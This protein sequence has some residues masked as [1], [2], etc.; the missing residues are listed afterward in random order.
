MYVTDPHHSKQYK[1][2]SSYLA[3]LNNESI[4]DDFAYPPSWK[5]NFARLNK[6]VLIGGP[7]DGVIA[8][9][10]SAQFGCFNRKETPVPM[11]KLR[12]SFCS[13]FQMVGMWHLITWLTLDK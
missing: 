8:P 13:G 1:K 9:W 7:D 4:S 3:A 12:V 5:S 2:Y 10:Q 6:V 11:R